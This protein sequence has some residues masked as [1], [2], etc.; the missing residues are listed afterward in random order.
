MY[1]LAVGSV[2]NALRGREILNKNG[3]NAKIQRYAGDKKMGCGYVL[4]VS[5]ETE[6][7]K[8]LLNSFGIKVMD[9]SKK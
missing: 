5:E 4:I 9:V 1:S 3:I 6:R 7:C 2:T 8:M